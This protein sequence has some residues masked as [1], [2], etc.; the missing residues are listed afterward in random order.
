MG[1]KKAVNL[2][3]ATSD[4]AYGA[5]D[6]LA[7]GLSAVRLN[8]GRLVDTVLPPQAFFQSRDMAESWADVRFLDEP[9]CARCGF[10]FDF[11]EGRDA[12]CGRCT[13]RPPRYD[14]ARAAFAYDD[15]SRR[16]VLAFKHGGR[17]EGLSMFGLQMT[18]AGRQLL[19]GAD[20]LVPVPLHYSR[21]IGRR[22]NQAALL[23]G[24]VS[25]LSGVPVQAHSL[26]RHK[27]TVSQGGQSVTG[28][29]RNVSGAFSMRKGADM[30]GQTVVLIDDVFTTGA[31][32]ESCARTLRKAGVKTV[33]GL[34]LAR[35]VKGA[36]V[37]T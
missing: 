36:A 26:M 30:R 20:A 31:T 11:N 29:R 10:P 16:A 14:K 6:V 3:R 2:A 34:V 22:Y 21:L 28:R 8:T 37:P 25:K 32:L 23:A 33:H 35:V 4:F 19:D 24:A 9:C 18:R 12:L 7:R 15:A 13:A 17:T 5:S 27:P 1:E